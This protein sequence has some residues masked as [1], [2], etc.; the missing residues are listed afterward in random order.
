MHIT[1]FVSR[2]YYGDDYNAKDYYIKRLRHWEWLWG[3]RHWLWWWRRRWRWFC[4]LFFNGG[5]VLSVQSG[6]L[7][8]IAERTQQISKRHE[9]PAGGLSTEV[10]HKQMSGRLMLQSSFT[11]LFALLAFDLCSP[12]CKPSALSSSGL[13]RS[14]FSLSL[15][16]S[17]WWSLTEINWS[18]CVQFEPLPSSSSSQWLKLHWQHWVCF[19]VECLSCSASPLLIPS[20]SNPLGSFFSAVGSSFPS[21]SLYVTLGFLL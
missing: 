11:W 18:R 14:V 19:S 3:S 21:V 13:Q 6:C 9:S 10:K 17:L 16:R 15:S 2:W 4:M 8:Y 20:V 5:S 12:A 7:L 1:I